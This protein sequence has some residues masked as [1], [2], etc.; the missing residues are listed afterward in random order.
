M[1]HIHKTIL[2]MLLSFSAPG[3]SSQDLTVVSWGGA[4]A[5]AQQQAINAPYTARTGITIINDHGAAEAVAKLRAMREAGNITWDV[6]DVAAADAIR[7]CDEGLAM[8]IHLDSH[9]P[10]APD[11]TL[12]SQDFGESQVSPC[13]IPH[14]VYSTAFAYRTDLVG[15]TPPQNVCD[16][17]DLEAYPGRRALERRPINNMEWALLCDGVAAEDIYTVLATAAGQAR[18][19]TKLNSIKGHVIW[20]SAG[21]NA[22]QLLADGEVV[23]ASGYNGRLF[24]LIVEER[25]PVAMLW[26]RQM[27]DFSGWIIPA[28]LGEVRTQRALDYVAFATATPQLATLASYIAYA[29]LRTSSLARVGRHAELDIDML[30]HMPTAPQNAATAFRYDYEFWADY[31]DD[32]DSRFHAWLAR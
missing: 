27:L 8:E 23:M 18:A 19:L 1:R 17:F 21:A 28:G 30:P 31:Q 10:P 22:P 25:Q 20:W 26:H 12:A 16:I 9:L 15:D 14:V 11:G 3:V 24:S 32:I 2:C 4:Y 29:P 7:L 5:R 13:L 6:V